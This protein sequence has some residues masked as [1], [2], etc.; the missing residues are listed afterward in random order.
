MSGDLPLL[1]LP[2]DRPR[3]ARLSNQGACCVLELPLALS[4]ELVALSRRR[5][6]TL[7]MT[8]LAAWAIQLARRSGREEMIIGMTIANRNLHETE[9]LIGFFVNTLPLRIDLSQATTFPELLDQMRD[10][11]LGA[12]T[13]QDVPLEK[14]VEEIQ[15]KRYRDGSPLFQVTF[16]I[17]N[18]P[19]E[20]I[21]I[22]GV[23]SLPGPG[24]GREMARFDLTIWVTESPSGLSVAWTYRTDLF[25]Q[26]TILTMHQ[27]FETLLGSIVEHPEAEIDSLET[28]TAAEQRAELRQNQARTESKRGKLMAVRP[29]AVKVAE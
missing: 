23:E 11:A 4:Q 24:A 22:P 8:L 9:G 25:E 13:H 27:S 2:A 18:A 21:E 20:E 1:D 12:F 10:V 17:Q 19:R 6:V 7:F 14:L 16:G 26:A 29:R 3:S 15:P 5:G 28:R